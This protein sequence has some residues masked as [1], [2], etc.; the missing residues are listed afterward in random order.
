MNGPCWNS[1][2]PPG[3]VFSISIGEGRRSG[4]LLRLNFLNASRWIS[5][6]AARMLKSAGHLFSHISRIASSARA[7]S[8][9]MGCARTVGAEQRISAAIQ[10]PFMKTPKS[11]RSIL[12]QPRRVRKIERQRAG[13]FQRVT[14]PSPSAPARPA[15]G[16]P[17]SGPVHPAA[18]RP[19]YRR[20]LAFQTIAGWR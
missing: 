19:K 18:L 20:F 10:R 14:W 17:R 2:T 11:K 12:P 13:C 4:A 7:S 15:G 9:E 5:T 6:Q 16:W 3:S 1:A 8:G